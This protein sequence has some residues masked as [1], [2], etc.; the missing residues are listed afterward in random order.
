MKIAVVGA[1][2]VGAT[3]A[4]ALM[5][6]GL[7]S[8]IVL[9]DADRRRAE[10]EAMDLAHGAPFARPVT[11][12]AG[13]LEDCAGARLVV[14]AAGAA[15]RPGQDRLD[16]LRANAEVFRSIVP[17][18]ARAAPD[19]VLL[20][21]SNPVDVLTYAAL[22]LS[23]FP[24]AR[25]IGSGTVLDTARLRSL[26]GQRLAI[27]PR[28]V[29]VY[30]VGEHGDSEVVLWSRAMVAGMPLDEFCRQRGTDCGAAE[31]AQLAAEVRRAAY[32]IIERKRA[33]YYA[34]GLGVRQVVEAILRSQ[35]TVLTVSSLL[36]GELGLADVCLSLPAVLDAGGV[37][38]L[39]VP[40]MDEPEAAALR[41][42][43]DV[44]RETAH[45]AGL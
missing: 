20:V 36:Q 19:S 32:E 45:A 31:R 38:H 6:G 1:G 7:A 10:G 35:R 26:V 37:G 11:V 42:S 4:Y 24:A 43:A 29:H 3:A 33:T 13:T 44:L 41:R 28:S 40:A 25:V 18:L 14:L 34:I 22:R 15:Q 16:L 17:P 2:L 8:E 21:V 5:I 12:R 23:G 30:V 27:D 9:V 39:L